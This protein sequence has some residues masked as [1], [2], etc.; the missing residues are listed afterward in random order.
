MITFFDILYFFIIPFLCTAILFVIVMLSFRWQNFEK[1]GERKNDWRKLEPDLL[2][3]QIE[4]HNNAIYKAFEFYIKIMLA[5]L[6]GISFIA[7]KKPDN[8][9]NVNVL[10]QCGGMINL[11]VT[12]LFCM[13]VIGHQKAKIERWKKRFKC[14][15][16][17][18]WNEL[19][20]V[21]TSVAFASFVY[22][23]VISKIIN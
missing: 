20:F 22:F 2:S 4:Y 9:L 1:S 11:G 6:G 8:T 15:E 7:L 18:F 3:S 23:I 17:I 14:H 13:L 5:L 12:F 19:W 21:C 10:I 16:I